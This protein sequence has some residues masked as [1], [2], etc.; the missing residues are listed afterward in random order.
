MSI[1]SVE[2]HNIE[3]LQHQWRCCHHNVESLWHQWRCWHHNVESLRHQW[4]CHHHNVESPWH[5]W[6]CS[7][8]NVECPWHQWRCCHHNIESPWHQWRCF[9]GLANETT[10]PWKDCPRYIHA[11]L[12][13][14]LASK[15]NSINTDTNMANFI[16]ACPPYLALFCFPVHKNILHSTVKFKSSIYF[17]LKILLKLKKFK[18]IKLSFIEKHL[19]PCNYF[20]FYM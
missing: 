4:R 1:D 12:S 8:H 19:K 7:H 14:I 10:F 11:S 6:W 15:Q 5:H 13:A 18:C 17:T 16:N 9:P 20:M 2:S 3:Y